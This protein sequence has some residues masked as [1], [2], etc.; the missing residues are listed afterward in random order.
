MTKA[1]AAPC[2]AQCMPEFAPKELELDACPPELGLSPKYGCKILVDYAC[3]FVIY[4]HGGY[5]VCTILVSHRSVSNVC[6]MTDK[7]NQPTATQR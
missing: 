1:G 3:M 5:I 7:E 4:A 2:L 6:D